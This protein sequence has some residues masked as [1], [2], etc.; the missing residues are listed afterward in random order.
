MPLESVNQRL[1]LTR[2]LKVSLEHI[3]NPRTK[4]FMVDNFHNMYFTTLCAT[5]HR[6]QCTST[7]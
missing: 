4:S 2:N 5:V 6:Y 3:G 1:D 7:R